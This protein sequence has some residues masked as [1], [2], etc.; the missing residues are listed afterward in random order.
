L[1]AGPIRAGKGWRWVTDRNKVET[2]AAASRRIIV[3]GAGILG[4][5][6]ALLARLAGHEVTL[7]DRSADPTATSAS[8]Y[9]GAMLSQDCEGEAAP[10]LV[11]DYGRS[12]LELWRAH[13]PRLIEAGSLVLAPARDRSELIRFARMTGG[14]VHLDGPGVAKLEPD[15][16]GRFHE[17]LYFADEAHMATPDALAYL[18]GALQEAG[19]RLAFGAQ[20][21]ASALG[22][23]DGLSPGD[24]LAFVEAGLCDVAID[25]RG[26]AAR[27]VLPDLRGVRGE[28]IVIGCQ[29]VRLSRP[30]RLLHPRHPLYIV[31]W[32]DGRFMV[33]A[34]VLESE[35]DGPASLRSVL[36]LL[37]A[38]YALHPGFGEA[39]VLEVSAGVRPAFPDNV[40]KARVEAGGRV[41]RVNG[42]Y[43][44]GFLLAP[45]LAAAVSTVL[46]GERI[47]HPLVEAR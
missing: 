21:M 28:R 22:G 46:S 17:G 25:C 27:D 38:A 35:D 39:E 2:S 10:A 41:I 34:T 37:G 42:A 24:P 23:L 1:K 47:D 33:G 45:V 40:P 32:G 6:Q 26:L 19:C 36:E 7:I 13:Y 9:A 29:D 11:R 44:H 31:P 8:H 20:A 12:G 4:I 16:D 18:I 14:H 30:V 15:L 43:R 3:V 5:W